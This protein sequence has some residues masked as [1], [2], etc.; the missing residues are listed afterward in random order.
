MAKIA[1]QLAKPDGLMVITP[2]DE[3][4]FL[5]PLDVEMLS[6]IGPKTGKLLKGH[7]IATLGDLASTDEPWL[8]R[9]LGR[10]GPELKGRAMGIDNSAV[11]SPTGRPSPS[12]QR[13]QW[14][15]TLMMRGSLHGAKA[16][17]GGRLCKAQ[18]VSA[19]R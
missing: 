6:G 9:V 19:D 1:S 8:V 15:E 5:A 14:P 11:L 10:R 4:D 17:L 7:G 16:S 2:G 12:V 3:K 18:K 13:P